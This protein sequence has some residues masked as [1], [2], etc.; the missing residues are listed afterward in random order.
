MKKYSK[1][2]YP[3]IILFILIASY[4]FI[5]SNLYSTLSTEYLLTST[6]T[7]FSG[8]KFV[9]DGDQCNNHTKCFYSVERDASCIRGEFVFNYDYSQDETI[10]KSP[11]IVSNSG[12]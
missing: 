5:N 10:T 6:P 11:I 4:M 8:C 9:R 1:Y 12:E 2:L 3:V 7:E